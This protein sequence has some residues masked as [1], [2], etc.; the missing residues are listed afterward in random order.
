MTFAL[1]K[2]NNKFVFAPLINATF[3]ELGPAH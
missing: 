2:D 3:G 1:E